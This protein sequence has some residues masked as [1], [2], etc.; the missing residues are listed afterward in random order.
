MDPIMLPRDCNHVQQLPKNWTLGWN[1]NG[2][3]FSYQRQCLISILASTNPALF[4]ENFGS[5]QALGIL[6]W[7]ENDFIQVTI[8]NPVEESTK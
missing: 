2:K 4:I 6:P 1:K 7:G 3:E 8:A 5:F